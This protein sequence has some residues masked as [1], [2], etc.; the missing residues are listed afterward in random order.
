MKARWKFQQYSLGQGRQRQGAVSYGELTR[1]GTA[2]WGVVS[3]GRPRRG[4]VRSGEVSQAK[5]RYQRAFMGARSLTNRKFAIA[6][7]DCVKTE[8]IIVPMRYN[9]RSTIRL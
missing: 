7:S 1:S 6:K 3:H 5:P 2:R 9:E 4:K 8:R